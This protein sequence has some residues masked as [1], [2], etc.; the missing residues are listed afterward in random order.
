MDLQQYISFR[1]VTE[2]LNIFIYYRMFTMIN[3]V[4]IHP[5]IE[6]LQYYWLYS[7]C[8]KLH[9]HELFIL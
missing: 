4:P 1:Y 7:L 3:L 2:W 8:Y 9:T 5:H 6:L